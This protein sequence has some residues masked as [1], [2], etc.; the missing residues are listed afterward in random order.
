VRSIRGYLLSRLVGGAVLVLGL[1]GVALF[2]VV[3]RA[4]EDEFDA[5][6]TGR[7]QA[8]ASILFQTG[9]HVE[10]EFSEQLMPEYADGERPAYFEL[11]FAGG[12]LLERS[13]SLAGGTLAVQAEPGP[14]PVHWTAPLPD[15]RE[16]RFVAQ[17]IEVHHVHPEE[18]P[19]RPEAARVRVVIASGREDLLA[20]ERGVLLSCAAA[21]ALLIGSIAAFSWVAVERGLEPAK[22][23]AARLDAIQVEHLPEHL[24]VGALPLE[25]APVAAKTDLL[26]RR[27]DEALARERRTTADIA[28]ELRTPISEILTAAEV[29]LRDDEDA[30]GARRA[31][32]TIRDSAQRMGVSLAT[33]L[34]LARLEMGAVAAHRGPVDLEALVRELLRPLAASARARELVVDSAL[35]PGATVAGDRELLA[36][37]LSNLLGNA[38]RYAR[39]A[40]RVACRLER[41]G[42]RWQIAVENRTDEL[43]PADLRSLS[44]P[45]W[46]KDRARTDREHSGL[47]LALSRA[48]AEK[49]GLTLTFE[50]EGGTFRALLAGSD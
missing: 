32:G 11:R 5:S 50:L 48:L 42:S 38:L 36:I 40:S 6:L 47:G 8:F 22:R 12:E 10:F 9:E 15:G 1:A 18:G 33:L 2:V 41:T 28:H 30:A 29:A 44:E 7:V 13:D 46:R 17:L 27:V 16:G 43:E 3:T 49:A 19:G 23:L 37:V 24:D 31:L 21:F 4:L 34:E 25:L 35:E 14:E 20:A 39:P 26:I 45:F